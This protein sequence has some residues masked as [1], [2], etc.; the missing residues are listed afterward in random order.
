MGRCYPPPRRVSMRRTSSSI[1]TS[2]T[3]SRL[4]SGENCRRYRPSGGL[5]SPGDAC[6]VGCPLDGRSPTRLCEVTAERTVAAVRERIAPPP[7]DRYE[8]GTR[9]RGAHVVAASKDRPSWPCDRAKGAVCK[10]GGEGRTST[11]GVGGVDTVSYAW[12][13][14][15]CPSLYLV[16]V[17]AW[18]CGSPRGR[19]EGGRMCGG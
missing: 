14:P 19:P 16:Y 4:N 11:A 5:P 9:R 15:V 8:V 12:P 18:R 6:Q 3:A 10:A 7:R 1:P 2:S 17:A 13:Q